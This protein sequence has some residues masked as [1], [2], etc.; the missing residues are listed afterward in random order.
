MEPDCTQEPRGGPHR[1]STTCL[2]SWPHTTAPGSLPQQ[3]LLALSD[4]TQPWG[5]AS[6]SSLAG[7]GLAGEGGTQQLELPGNPSVMAPLSHAPSL[8][9]GS[10]V[11]LFPLLYQ[12]VPL[13][14]VQP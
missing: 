11:C 14:A 2:P 12:R 3:T 7:S 13:H 4:L 9:P 10:F 5:S 8:L 1:P 6:P